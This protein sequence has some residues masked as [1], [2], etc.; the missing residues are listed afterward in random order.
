M[1]KANYLLKDQEI[2]QLENIIK[3][4]KYEYGKGN[5]VF[6]LDGCMSAFIIA[7]TKKTQSY[8]KYLGKGNSGLMYNKDKEMILLNK[9]SSEIKLKFLNG[10]F[11]PIYERKCFITQEKIKLAEKWSKGFLYGISTV[12]PEFLK[13]Q[14]FFSIFIIPLHIVGGFT[15]KEKLKNTKLNITVEN[16]LPVI[17]SVIE[18]IHKIFRD[19]KYYYISKSKIELKKDVLL[20]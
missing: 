6:W 13:N 20:Q 19:K 2:E 10:N 16:T 8:Q 1:K 17:P 15:T 12:A 11:E 5:D 14:E 9:L 4:K 18:N 7:R 3:E